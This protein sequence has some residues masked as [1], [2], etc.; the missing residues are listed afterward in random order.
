MCKYVPAKA[1]YEHFPS[2]VT[3]HL[4]SFH[5]VKQCDTTLCISGHT[6]KTVRKVFLENPGLLAD[7]GVGIMTE[8]TLSSVEEFICRLYGVTQTNSVDPARHSFSRRGK[9]ENLPL[10]SNALS[11]H[12]KKIGVVQNHRPPTSHRPQTTDHR[13]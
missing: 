7:V 10:T 2:A 12:V 3:K 9:P 5:A 11:F 1:T 8:N 6:N 13:P 4:I